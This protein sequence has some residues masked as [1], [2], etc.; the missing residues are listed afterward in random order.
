MAHPKADLGV[1]AF[2]Q[3]DFSWKAELEVLRA[4]CVTATGSW[5]TKDYRIV[6]PEIGHF[7]KLH[8]M[9]KISPLV[10]SFEI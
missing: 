10:F 4:L 2:F 9:Q 8:Q 3:K 5:Q 1:D 6:S 7:W